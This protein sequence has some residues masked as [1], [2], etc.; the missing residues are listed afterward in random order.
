MPGR[1]AWTPRKI[2]TSSPSFGDVVLVLAP[3]VAGDADHRGEQREHERRTAIRRT[4]REAARRLRGV[5]QLLG[6]DVAVVRLGP[7]PARARRCRRRGRPRPAESAVAAGASAAAPTIIGP[8]TAERWSRR[9]RRVVVD[10]VGHHD[11]DVVGAA[12]LEG[13]RGPAHDGD[14]G[15]V[16]SP[17]MSGELV[18]VEAR[19]EQPSE[20]SR[21]RS[22]GASSRV[23]TSGSGSWTPS[24]ARRIRL[25]CGWIRASSSVIRPSSIRLCTKVWSLVSCDSVPS[26]SR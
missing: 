23:K 24:T 17:R 25:R 14:V 20:Q 7:R 10:D 12:G 3:P 2:A 4:Q 8:V 21:S 13:R 22:P 5:A 19:P 11:G 15:R 9:R 1:S 26:R 18:V 6:V 16:P